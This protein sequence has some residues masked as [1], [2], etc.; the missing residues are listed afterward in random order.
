MRSDG[1]EGDT[2]DRRVEAMVEKGLFEEVASLLSSGLSPECTAMQA[3]GYKEV[4]AYLAGDYGLER[5]RE[6]VCRNTRR[7][8]KRQLSWLRRDCRAR[9]LDLSLYSADEAAVV[10]A[11][12]WRQS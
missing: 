11:D 7:Y 4:L 3:I 8:A 10:I 6:L 5:A 1:E 2:D 9:E 12:D